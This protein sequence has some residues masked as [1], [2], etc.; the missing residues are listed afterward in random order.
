VGADL[1]PTSS[2]IMRYN[3]RSWAVTFTNPAVCFLAVASTSASD[4]WAVGGTNCFSPCYTVAEHWNSKTWTRV[5]TPNPGGGGHFQGV[6]A[7]SASNRWA[8]GPG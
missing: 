5:R 1:Q 4:A 2:L 3:G 7:T 6:A 8:V